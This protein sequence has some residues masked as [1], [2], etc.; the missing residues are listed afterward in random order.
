MG[1]K[2]SASWATICGIERLFVAQSWRI[3]GQKLLSP[4]DV[5]RL[6][7]LYCHDFFEVQIVRQFCFLMAILSESCSCEVCFE[8]PT[9]GYHL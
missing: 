2:T 7:V 3:L 5:L 9:V 4:N 8:H 1:G 6:L